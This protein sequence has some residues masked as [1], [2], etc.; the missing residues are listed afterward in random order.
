VNHLLEIDLLHRGITLVTCQLQ[1]SND[2]ASPMNSVTWLY[3]YPQLVPGV[4]GL[5]ED[6]LDFVGR[7]S[8]LVRRTLYLMLTDTTDHT[9]DKPSLPFHPTFYLVSKYVS[10]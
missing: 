8:V 1:H 9:N 4:L 2:T 10:E 3:T 6:F 5:V 7:Q